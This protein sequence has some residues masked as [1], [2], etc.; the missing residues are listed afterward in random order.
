M[1]SSD[2]VN[3][4]RRTRASITVEVVREDSTLSLGV[5]ALSSRMDT[6]MT[7][8]ST[9]PYGLFKI[10]LRTRWV[11][12]ERVVARHERHGQLSCWLP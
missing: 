8:L 11:V 9:A 4:L 2:V 10:Q 1:T 3:V 7:G 6:S 12:A 5:P